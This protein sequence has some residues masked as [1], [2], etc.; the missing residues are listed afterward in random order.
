MLPLVIFL[1]FPFLIL[2]NS[3]ELVPIKKV[4]EEQRKNNTLVLFGLAY[5]DL[6]SYYKLMSVLERDPVIIALGS[7]RTLQ[8]RSAFF[9]KNAEF[10]NAGASV[11]KIEDFK[12]FLNKIPSQSRLRIII[13]GLD[14]YFFNPNWVKSQEYDDGSELSKR[15]DSLEAWN[16]GWRKAYEDYSNKK[17]LL[18]ELFVHRY[19]EER[20]GLNAIVNSNGFRND[21]SYYYGKIISNPEDPGNEDYQFQ[22]T[23][24]RINMGVS[25]FEYSKDISAISVDELERFLIYCHERNIY[26]IGFLPPFAPSVY[27]LIKSKGLKYQYIFQLPSTLNP[28]FNKYHFGFY[29][30]TDISNLGS[31]DKETIDGFHGSEKAYLRLFIRMAEKE[32]VLKEYVDINYLNKKLDNSK[33]D[34]L[35]F[36]NN[37]F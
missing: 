2:F 34:Y 31:S 20:V 15:H 19:G 6:N 14:Q 16:L 30:F 1:G 18:K 7:S 9:R 21:G 27:N 26:V 8:F 23:L 11:G 25:R 29:D 36:K 17:F 12:H 13:V 10:F 4:I 24:R 33:S 28:I 5:R 32:K 35:V 22:N 37:E 3:R